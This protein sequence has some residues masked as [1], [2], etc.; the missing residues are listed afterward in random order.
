MRRASFKVGRTPWID[1]SRRSRQS[2]RTP[3]APNGI[4]ALPGV[5]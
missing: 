5:P 1:D 2:N 3:D 4:V